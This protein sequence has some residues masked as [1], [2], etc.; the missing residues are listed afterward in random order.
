[1]TDLKKG[2]K[3]KVK[4]AENPMIKTEVGNVVEIITTNDEST[5]FI[6]IETSDWFII[7]NKNIEEYLKK[8]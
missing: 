6:D 3:F 2:M 4:K 5:E 1:M 8:I 7:D